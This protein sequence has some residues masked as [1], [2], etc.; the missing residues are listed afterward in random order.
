V[1]GSRQAPLQAQSVQNEGE[2]MSAQIQR[3]HEPC[4]HA[5][6]ASRAPWRGLGAAAR[7][8]MLV[9]AVL[10]IS[11]AAQ[12]QRPDKVWRIGYLAG[13]SRVPQID[14]L[15][16]GLHELGYVEGQNL[17][18]DMKLANGQL[19]KLPALA[20]ELVQ[21]KPDVIVAAANVA[22]LAAKAATST[23][24]IVVVSSHA[25]VEVGLFKSLA[26]PGGNLTGIESLALDL[27]VERLEFLK[28]A[29]P[30]MSKLALLYNPTA[31]GSALHI[32]KIKATAPS[33]G[34]QVRIVEV[35]SAAEFDA[36]FAAILSDRPDAL[37]TVGDPLMFAY[38]ERVVQFTQAH[39]LPA[40]HEFKIF[41]DL[42]GLM[43]YGPD[44]PALWRRAAEYADKILKGAKP[45]D[46]PVEQPTNFELIINLKAA[47]ALGLAIPPSLLVRAD[48]VIE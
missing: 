35:R 5:G 28:Q 23:I 6:D 29:L 9:T 40:I 41:A 14:A 30:Q 43:S 32:D 21:L 39:K 15:V 16:Q 45:A 48:E 47:Q 19:D 26:R 25:G 13:S 7:M 4:R 36:A 42:G 11:L 18:L 2:G 44:V 33:L 31:A 20:A 10:F 24:P 34:M 12:A 22:A 37:M 38:R 27:D 46:L 3:L 17:V 1:C 8:L